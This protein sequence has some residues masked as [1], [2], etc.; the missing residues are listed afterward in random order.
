MKNHLRTL[1]L[2]PFLVVAAVAEESSDPNRTVLDKQGTLEKQTFW[3]NRDWTWF[4]E[5]IPMLETPDAEIDTTWYYRWELVTKHLV[6]G[7]P[8]DGYTFTEFTDRPRWSGTYGAIVCPA[9]HVAREVRWLRSPRVA[10][11]FMRYWF[12]ADG[13]QPERYSSWLAD[14]LWQIHLAHPDKAFALDLFPDLL[15]YRERWVKKHFVPEAGM[16]WQSGMADGM[17]TNIN[18]RQ[19]KNWFAGA[20]GYRPTMNSYMWAD[21]VA[22]AKLATLAGDD[23]AAADFQQQAAKLKQ[24]VQESLWDPERQF[25]FQMN[26]KDEEKKDGFA[27][28]AGK[29]THRSGKFDGSPHGRELIGYVPWAFGLPDRDKGY[30]QAWKFLMDPAYFAAPFGPLTVER[31]DPL[32]RISPTCCVWSG[33]SWPFATTQTLV[34]LAN[35]LQD[36]EQDVVDRQDY[37]QLLKIYTLTH[38]HGGHPYIAEALNP[39]TG[40]FAGHNRYEHS[41]HY[42]HSGYCDLIV[43]GLIGLRPRDDEMI[44]VNPLVPEK[45]DFFAL[46]DLSYRG[47]RISVVWDR[48]GGKYGKGK[49]LRILLN[50]ETIAESEK[51]GRL[52][53]KLPQAVSTVPAESD[54]ANYAVNNTLGYFPKFS[55]S[56]SSPDSRITAIGD[57]QVWYHRTPPNR[58]TSEGSE[59]ATDWAM[60]DF[61]IAR[62][63]DEVK[64]YFLDDRN[65]APIDAMPIYSQYGERP[66][67]LRPELGPPAVAPPASYVL[68]YRVGDEWKPIPGQ[69]RA[70][71]SPVGRRANSIRFPEIRTTAIRAVFTH[72]KGFRVGLSEFEAWGA[73]LQPLPEAPPPSGNL[74]VNSRGEGFPK[75]SASYIS[76]FDRNIYLVNDGLVSYR[77]KPHNRWTAMQSPNRED[78]VELDFGKRVAFSRVVLHPYGERGKIQPPASYDLQVFADGEWRSIPD[79]AKTPPEPKAASPNVI[80][81]EPQTAQKLRVVFKHRDEVW[82]GLTEIEVWKPSIDR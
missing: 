24:K 18:S 47:H 22:L 36:Y 81:F 27:I 37:F 41:E 56:H 40:S 64:L 78:W 66:D 58:W 14:S 20:H 7:S 52:T 17:E 50:G 4:A 5:N 35:V 46:D 9:G 65:A 55:A 72:A 63:V 74:A 45:W 59:A 62:P 73:Q 79:Q 33:N 29:L 48:T 80:T 44:E 25:F 31:N 1:V 61:G 30:E 19:T 38:R 3:D 54:Q 12:R 32:F 69:R 57:G 23:D 11:D 43:T 53:A 39:D 6:Y 71:E 34:A 68:E 67:T 10:R 70:L 28:Q 21:A 8:E 82:S 2:A 16:F 15:K 49:G 26:L 42:F 77:P 13:A 51:M 76:K 60:V 75:P